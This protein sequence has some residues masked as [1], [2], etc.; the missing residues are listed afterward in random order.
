MHDNYALGYVIHGRGEDAH[1]SHAGRFCYPD[2]D[3]TGAYFHARGD[4]TVF[5][6]NWSG[7]CV[8]A[9]D[10]GLGTAI[11]ATMR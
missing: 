11:S 8:S 3:S 5:S 1:A 6:A 2:G 7:A 4:G 9:S 10:T